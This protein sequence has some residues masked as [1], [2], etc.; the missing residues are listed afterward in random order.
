MQGLMSESNSS[1]IRGL[2]EP[3]YIVYPND[4]QY[5]WAYYFSF[6]VSTVN[7]LKLLPE[8]TDI[9]VHFEFIIH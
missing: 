8:L 1:S 6:S 9:A 3:S 2:R 5:S 4:L 7:V